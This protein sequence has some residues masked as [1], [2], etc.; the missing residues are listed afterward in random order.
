MRKLLLIAAIIL[1]LSGCKT[2]EENYRKA[3]DLA[4]QG[5]KNAQS[6]IPEISGEEVKVQWAE[7]V[8]FTD[9]C[10]ADKADFKKHCVVVAQFKQVFNAK[11]M[12]NR[13]A[14][15]KYPHAIVIND[16]E[17]T[18]YVVA[19]AFDTRAEAENA[20]EN[21]SKDKDMSLKAPYPRLLIAR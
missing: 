3:Y 13:L 21:V 2:T 5:D 7:Y 17:K 18:Y 6:D 15:G 10:G 20:L 8:T 4:T 11:A 1:T 9:G 12:R 14:E 19:A 16:R